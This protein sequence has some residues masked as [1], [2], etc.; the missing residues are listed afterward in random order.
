[1]AR[2]RKKEEP[3]PE[4]AP[5]NPLEGLEIAQAEGIPWTEI[6]QKLT[7]VIEGVARGDVKATAAQ[8]SMIKEIL[9]QSKEET[10]ATARGARGVILLPTQGAGPTARLDQ[11][12]REQIR[13][14][15]TKSGDDSKN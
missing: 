9:A 4:V 11:Q 13:A 7:M 5:E 12:M 3:A 10:A 6:K 2:S 8:V 14:I 15:E 1:M